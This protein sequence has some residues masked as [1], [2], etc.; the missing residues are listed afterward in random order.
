MNQIFPELPLSLGAYTLTHFLGKREHS[1]IYSAQQEHVDRQV[2]I[3]VLRPDAD[4]A[5]ISQFL[6]TARA[7]VNAKLPGV[8]QVF[9]SMISDG[10]WY[11]TQEKPGGLNLETLYRQGAQLTPIQVCTILDAVSQLY[12]ACTK[13]KLQAGSLSRTDIFLTQG[14]NSSVR[15]LSPI[16]DNEE[17]HITQAELMQKL[18]EA[19]APLLPSNVAGQTRIAT[20]MQWVRDGYD[21][22]HL[23]WTAVSAT[24]LMIEEQL[25][26]VLSTTTPA[27]AEKATVG[28][29]QRTQLKKKRERKHRFHLLVQTLLFMILC[30]AIGGILAPT[31]PKALSP[32]VGEHILCTPENGHPSSWISK[33]PVSIIQYQRFLAHYASAPTSELARINRGL[34][35]TSLNFTPDQWQ[36]QLHAAANKSTWQGRQLTE[37][38]PVCG[39]SYWCALAY[40]NYCRGSL[41]SLREIS[42]VQEK[43]GSSRIQ[44]WTS[45]TQAANVAL[46]TCHL[47]LAADSKK[48]IKEKD[49][50]AKNASRGF[51][52]ALPTPPAP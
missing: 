15:F 47:V 5:T 29:L 48:I 33:S 31:E 28:R 16:Y 2:L 34:P 44:E 37:D 12:I 22:E 24:A 40:A 18:A 30:G 7:R 45:D 39:V 27:G 50:T 51:R 1:E 36:E 3:E 26:P 20:L 49:P 32:I 6:K 52:I 38:S 25:S 17:R 11:I 14:K 4:Q 46:S 41:P 8:A 10:T 42:T 21:G 35:D 23:D 13:A 19:L 43:I 9:E